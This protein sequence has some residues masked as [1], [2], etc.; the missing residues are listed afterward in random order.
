MPP[1]NASLT[2]TGTVSLSNLVVIYVFRVMLSSLVLSYPGVS[3]I[4]IQSIANL[5]NILKENSFWFPWTTEEFPPLLEWRVQFFP[6]SGKSSNYLW[7][8][9]TILTRLQNKST[10]PLCPVMSEAL[11]TD[12][13]TRPSKAYCV[14]RV[15][16]DEIP[17]GKSLGVW[18]GE[19]EV[20]GMGTLFL[21]LVC[22]TALL[23]GH[24]L[25]ANL[26][27]EIR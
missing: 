9:N 13:L 12:Y 25:F 26:A 11:H 5:E 16:E 4:M 1:W 10:S 18:V 8:L 17:R 24:V 2:F 22:D 21:G 14:I 15:N 6:N 3:L 20:S 27:Q 23:K 19:S 7:G